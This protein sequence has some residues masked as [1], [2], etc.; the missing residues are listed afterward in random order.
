MKGAANHFM[1]LRL[2]RA[3][4]DIGG[5]A[6]TDGRLIRHGRVYRSG[7]LRQLVDPDHDTLARLGLTWRLDLRSRAERALEQHEWPGFAQIPAPVVEHEGLEGVQPA[8]WAHRIAD[9]AFTPAHAAQCLRA[10]YVDMPENLAPTLRLLIDR[11]LAPDGAPVL[12]HCTAGKDRTGFVCAM[13]QTALDVPRATIMQDYLLANQHM[14]DAQ[15]VLERMLGAHGLSPHAGSLAA[16]RAIFGVRRDYLD[17][18]FA[19]I[20]RDWGSPANYLHEAIGLDNT[21]LQALQAQLLTRA[22]T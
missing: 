5:L 9:P 12:V 6:T 4:R 15:P 20:E 2:E 21:R 8:V 3:F 16:V 18:A 22:Q 14:P 17:A 7:L 19:R 10:V 11:L 1:P 13:L